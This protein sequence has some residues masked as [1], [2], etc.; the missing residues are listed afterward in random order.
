MGIFNAKNAPEPAPSRP[1]K[2]AR[3]VA[4]VIG[5]DTVFEGTLVTENSVCIEGTLRGRLESRGSVMLS[6]TGTLEADVIAAHV[7]VNGTVVGNVTALEQLDVGT[8]GVIRGDVR[9]A[10]VTVAKGG[11]LDGACR[12]GGDNGEDGV[13]RGPRLKAVKSGKGAAEPGSAAEP[14]RAASGA[15]GE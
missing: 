11:V 15:A 4:T 3:S 2:D 10:S 6:P 1:S 13:E 9:A 5:K 12:M 7:S 14:A 8:S